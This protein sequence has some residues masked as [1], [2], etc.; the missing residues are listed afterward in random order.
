MAAKVQ[1]LLIEDVEDLGRSGDVVSVEPGFARNFLMPRK[2]AIIANAT[3]LRIQ[4]ELKE[5][6]LKKAAIEKQEADSIAKVLEGIVV[7]TNVKIDH[8]GHM[9]GSV[10]AHDIVELLKIQTNIEL[11]KRNIALKHAIKETGIHTVT[12]KLK[13]GV[14]SSFTLKVIPEGSAD[15]EEPQTATE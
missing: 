8:D 13:E 15:L 6:R 14:T 10:S 3:T 11:E 5:A 2:Y 12:V 1:L 9:Y 4:D 7:K